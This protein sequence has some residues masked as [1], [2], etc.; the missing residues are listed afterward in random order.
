[1][2]VA[3]PSMA[4]DTLTID[5]CREMALTYNKQ[6]AASA[7]AT[8][9]ALYTAKSYKGNF[10][11]NIYLSGTGLYSTA[12]GSF[13]IDGGYLPTFLADAT[14][15]LAADGGYAYFPGVDLDYDI[16]AVFMGGVTIEQPIYM[17]GKINAAYKLALIGKDIAQ[18]QETLTAT[19]VI[20]KTDEAYAGVV[21]AAETRKVAEAYQALLGELMK[22]VESAYRH[23]MKP[24][25]DVLKVQVRLNESELSLRKAENALRLAKMNLC[26]YIGRQ[27]TDDINVS[28]E[29]PAVVVP[30]D[31]QTLDVSQRPE[32][33]ILE[34]QV[35]MAHQ[36]VKLNRSEM[37]PQVG[38]SASYNYLHGI[39][40]NDNTLLDNGNFTALLNV[41]IPIFHF[42]ERKNKV[43]AAKS[44]LLE[45]QMEQQDVNEQMLLELAQAANNLDEAL[46]EVDIA[47]RSLV[48]AE[49]NMR[50]SRSQYDAGMETL[51]DH[52]EAQTLWQ[53]AY[54]EKVDAA[55][56]LY[57]SYVAYQKAAG[58]LYGGE[59]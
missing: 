34:K 25:N 26:H 36:Q 11:P 37:L 43:S 55:Y 12:D 48:Q 46:L 51:S 47:E 14:G 6:M 24:K 10:F 59:Q 18:K 1:M 53:Q 30:S 52:L 32:Y 19:E 33:A 29:M 38:L 40:V 54:Q 44:R 28:E 23:G 45:T 57:L 56:Q 49:E 13:G 50:V 21:K 58:T 35:D 17:G 22:D 8:R 15:S 9:S 39:D 16:D 42:G 4:Q 7:H 2:L 31:L 27:L 41:S 3:L 20:Q 5:E